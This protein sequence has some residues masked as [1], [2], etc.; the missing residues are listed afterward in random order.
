MELWLCQWIFWEL[1]WSRFWLWWC[2]SNLHQFQ[3][4][5]TIISIR[6]PS[7]KK[8][9]LK[10]RVGNLFK[11]QLPSDTERVQP[12]TIYWRYISLCRI[13]GQNCVMGQNAPFS[14]TNFL[15]SVRS[16]GGGGVP[17]FP[18]R[19]VCKLFGK[20]SSIEAPFNRIFCNKVWYDPTHSAVNFQK[21]CI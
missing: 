3:P 9:F 15:V 10:V 12:V 7:A 11:I 8:K 16:V 4:I 13:F 2:S 5:F 19:N 17:L 14:A 21:N 1:L 20:I 6:I 18:L